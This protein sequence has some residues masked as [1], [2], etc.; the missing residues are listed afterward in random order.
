M[1]LVTLMRSRVQGGEEW[2]IGAAPGTDARG[3]RMCAL[4]CGL[5][6]VLLVF[7]SLLNYLT[8][9]PPPSA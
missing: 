4:V 8:S 1:T 9:L 6:A 5:G 3:N 2:S 7:A